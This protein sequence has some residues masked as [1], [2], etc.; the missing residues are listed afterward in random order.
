MY[1]LF[2]KV[3]V[4]WM[5][6]YLI[7]CRGNFLISEKVICLFNDKYE[8]FVLEMDYY[9]LVCFCKLVESEI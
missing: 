3:I 2:Y 6:Y 4:V 9:W 1:D 7:K 8:I 5:G